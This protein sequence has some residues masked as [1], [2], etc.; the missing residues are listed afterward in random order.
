[1][2]L[3]RRGAPIGREPQ[4]DKTRGKT[5][6]SRHARKTDQNLPEEEPTAVSEHA[7]SPKVSRAITFKRVPAESLNASYICGA[8]A[9]VP[10]MCAVSARWTFIHVRVCKVQAPRKRPASCPRTP[11]A[12]DLYCSPC[13][14]PY[15]AEQAAQ[16]GF[17]N[18]ATSGWAATL[19]RR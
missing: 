4:A 6:R 5:R 1:M 3:R 18:L 2:L 9:K 11:T 13:G 17:S 12:E 8:D 16:L 19:L 10:S 15:Y 14:E 7:D